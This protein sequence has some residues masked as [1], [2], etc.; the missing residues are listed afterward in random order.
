MELKNALEELLKSCVK[1][2]VDNEEAVD[3]KITDKSDQENQTCVAA[4]IN[5]DAEDVG[6]VVGRR[7]RTIKSIRT[8]GR[9][10]GAKHDAR[11]EVEIY[12]EGRVRPTN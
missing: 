1:A 9:A 4:E 12:E 3:I 8:L 2:L 5:V 11:V 7:G 6:K 10:L